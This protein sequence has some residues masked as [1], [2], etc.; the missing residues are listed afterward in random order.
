MANI[1][2]EANFFEKSARHMPT[3][4]ADA[5]ESSENARP[6]SVSTNTILSPSQGGATAM[7]EN[8]ATAS[9][10][11]VEPPH[12]LRDGCLRIFTGNLLLRE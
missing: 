10:A 4:P 11:K 5:A 12:P 6:C 8:V 2:R 3:L 9:A 1:A 7:A